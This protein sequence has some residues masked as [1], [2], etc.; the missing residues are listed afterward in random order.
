MPADLNDHDLDGLIVASPGNPSGTM[1]DRMALSDLIHVY[2]ARGIPFI[3]DEI[4]HGLHYGDP[5]VS[6]RWKSAMRLGYSTVSPNILSMP[7][8]ASAGW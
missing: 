7:V 8:G 5:A 1:L 3:S 6:V 2:V 4:Y